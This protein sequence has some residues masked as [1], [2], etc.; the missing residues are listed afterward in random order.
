M[1]LGVP[2]P[3]EQSP[4][5]SGPTTGSLWLLS[6]KHQRSSTK[7]HRE[8]GNNTCFSLSPWGDLLP[9]EEDGKIHSLNTRESKPVWVGNGT[10]PRWSQTGEALLFASA[11]SYPTEAPTKE[12]SI[13]FHQVFY[14]G[15]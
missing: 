14:Y 1:T 9:F 5:V 4:A 2:E 15:T 3:Q 7:G 13:L 6:V 8:K 10:N 12:H 11:E